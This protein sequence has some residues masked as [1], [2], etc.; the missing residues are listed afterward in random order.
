MYSESNK[1]INRYK[2]LHFGIQLT[3]KK[4]RLVVHSD[5]QGMQQIW[6]LLGSAFLSRVQ[7]HSYVHC[8]KNFLVVKP[9]HQEQRRKLINKVKKSYLLF[10][11][12]N[13]AKVLIELEPAHRKYRILELKNRMCT[14]S[15]Y[16]YDS[17][18]LCRS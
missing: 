17:K 6:G 11:F 10:L 15:Q 12:G 3:C 14:S 8:S 5:C 1:E 2:Y 16:Y 13:G 18:W 9:V 4:Y 7:G